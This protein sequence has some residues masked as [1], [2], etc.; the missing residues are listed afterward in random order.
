MRSREP[1]RDL[2]DM[3]TLRW[4]RLVGDTLFA[5]GVGALVFFIAGSTTGWSILRLMGAR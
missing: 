3:Q 1:A 5:T 4:L 2:A